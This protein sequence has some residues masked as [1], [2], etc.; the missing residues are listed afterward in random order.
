MANVLT[1]LVPINVAVD[2]NPVLVLSVVK[3]T[4][5]PSFATMVE[6]PKVTKPSL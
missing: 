5:V 4:V 1:P 6:K 3:V 2:S